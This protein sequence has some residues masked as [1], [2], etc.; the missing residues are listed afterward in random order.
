MH[1]MWVSPPGRGYKALNRRAAVADWYYLGQASP[2]FQTAVEQIFSLY[3]QSIST[4]DILVGALASGLEFFATTAME[5]KIN[6]SAT[7]SR[8]ACIG[9]GFSGIG[10]GATL[11]RWYGITDIQVFEREAD[12]GGTWFINKYPGTYWD[13]S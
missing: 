11:K 10:I 12:L 8:F 2:H 6:R 9:A 1:V 4:F 13:C 7:Y 3:P 5:T